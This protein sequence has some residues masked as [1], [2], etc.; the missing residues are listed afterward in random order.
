MIP[1]P[2]KNNKLQKKNSLNFVTLQFKTKVKWVRRNL[3]GCPTSFLA[4][5]ARF[6]DFYL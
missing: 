3:L 4:E 6:F 2:N 1:G 5:I